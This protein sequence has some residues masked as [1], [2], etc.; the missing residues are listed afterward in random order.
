MRILSLQYSAYPDDSA[1]VYNVVY[2]LHRRFV[3]KGHNVYLVVSRV[4][5]DLPPRGKNGGMN[6][7]RITGFSSSSAIGKLIAVLLEVRKVT[8]EI[9]KTEGIDIIHIH[10]P[11]MGMGAY[12]VP[13][14]WSIPKVYHFHSSW[15]QEEEKEYIHKRRGKKSTVLFNLVLLLIKKTESFLLRSAK[16][17]IV[18]S[19]YSRDLVVGLFRISSEKILKIAGGVDGS[20]YFPTTDKKKV[21]QNLGLPQDK[22]ILFTVRAFI[23]RTGIEELIEAFSQVVKNR[24]DIFLVIGGKGRLRGRIEEMIK[25]RNLDEAVKVVGFIPSEKL[26]S[27]YQAADIFVLPTQEQEGFGLVTVEALASG[28]PV[29]GTPVGG[30][31]E[32]L[33]PLDSNLLFDSTSPEAIVKGILFWV[34]RPERLEEIRHK[35]RN[36]VMSK[37]SWDTAASDLERTFYDLVGESSGGKVYS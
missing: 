6:I 21:R 10:N 35:C 20:V 28:V 36:Y 12:L 7:Y 16:R 11:L 33:K 1:G 4:R 23:A 17:I 19:D 25:E 2:N 37:Y 29:L 13:L 34:Q 22:M 8:K 27:Y 26:P 18:L 9:I 32:I 24:D 5:R 15:F 31:E 30:T 3:T 14:S